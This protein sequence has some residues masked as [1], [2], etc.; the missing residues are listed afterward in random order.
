MDVCK[1]ES[2]QKHESKAHSADS[3]KAHPKPRVFTGTAEDI[4]FASINLVC[5]IKKSNALLERP[6]SSFSSKK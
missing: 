1:F 6:R 5:N 4:R 3:S 2:S